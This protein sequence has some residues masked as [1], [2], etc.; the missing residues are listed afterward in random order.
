MAAPS[1]KRVEDECESFADA[2]KYVFGKH[3]RAQAA[4]SDLSRA[5]Q[6]LNSGRSARALQCLNRGRSKVGLSAVA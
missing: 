4:S 2:L 6:H 5:V 3:G 1:I